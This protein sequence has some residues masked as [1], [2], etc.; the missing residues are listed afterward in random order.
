MSDASGYIAVLIAVLFFGSNFV[1]VKR[2]D[3]HDGMYYQW[4]M[5]SAIWIFGLLVQLYLFAKPQPTDLP[6]APTNATCILLSGRPDPYSVKFVPFAAFGGAMWATGNTLAV[7]CINLIGLSLGL[8]I[9]GS[10]NMLTG[11]ATGKFGLFGTKPDELS[12][13]NL[14]VA[15]VVLAVIALGIYTQIRPNTS[16]GSDGKRAGSELVNPIQEPFGGAEAELETTD[17]ELLQTRGERPAGASGAARAAGVVM[18]LV[19]GVLY[20]NNFTPPDY[21]MQNGLGPAAPLDYVFSHFTGI[22]AASTLYFAIYCLLMRSAPRINPR[23][24][25]P[26]MLSGLMWAT[27][28]TCWFIAN[29]ALS[30]SVA[31]PIITSGPGIVSA[32]WGVLVFG[33][34]SGTRNYV[35]LCSAIVLA[36]TGCTMIGMSK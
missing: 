17:A 35:V 24:T 1:T 6:C 22:F 2:F 32:L 31:F 14:N 11:W 18:A 5:C 19:S 28:Q 10:A 33:E 8:L 9:W 20:G 27:A 25:L 16:G 29:D 7:P 3:T 12:D 13:G 34:I 15:G 21:V 26:G 4:V 23:V 30:V 36:L